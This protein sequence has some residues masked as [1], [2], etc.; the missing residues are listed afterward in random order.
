MDRPEGTELVSPTELVEQLLFAPASSPMES[1]QAFTG[2]FTLT[3]GDAC[4]VVFVPV[5]VLGPGSVVLPISLLSAV[6][7]SEVESGSVVKMAADS[8]PVS[9]RGD[10]RRNGRHRK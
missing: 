8:S 7:G 2:A 4:V 5:G 10:W 1:E 3:R 6:T 9:S